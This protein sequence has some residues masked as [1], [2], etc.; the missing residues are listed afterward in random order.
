MRLKAA[1][2]HEFDAYVAEGSGITTKA[3][4]IVLQEIFGVNAHI[5]SVT[6]GYVEGGFCAIAPALFDRAER[7]LQLG[8]SPEDRKRGMRAAAQ[9]GLDAALRDVA[10]AIGYAGDRFGSA[11]VGVVGYC[12]GGTLAWLAATRLEPAAAVAYYGGQISKHAE[13]NPHCPVMLHFGE[14]DQH[15]PPSE[16]DNIRRR[17]P[18]LPLYLYGAGHGF[19]CEQRESYDAAS[20]ALARVRTLE[21]LR[22]HL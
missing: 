14:K 1:D 7:N 2:G 21:F 8:Y 11:K 3:A 18:N 16:I 5:R 12:W 13:E 9:V 4:V 22:K 10:A 17:H 20:A 15:I 19:N 6:D